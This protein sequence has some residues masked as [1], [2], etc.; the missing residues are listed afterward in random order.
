MREQGIVLLK[1][2]GGGCSGA[3]KQA[4]WFTASHECRRRS[5]GIGRMPGPAKVNLLQEMSPGKRCAQRKRTES[6]IQE[7]L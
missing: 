1:D 4:E 6:C 5:P 2:Q 3:T 7:A